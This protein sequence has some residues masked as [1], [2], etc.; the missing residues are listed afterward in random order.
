MPTYTH[1][2]T[3]EAPLDVVWS[4]HDGVDGLLALTPDF[5]HLRVDGMVD[6]AGDPTSGPLE[7]GDRVSLSMKPFGVLPRVSWTSLIVDEVEEDGRAE[8][9]DEMVAGPFDRWVHTHTFEAA[10]GDEATVCRDR[11]EYRPSLWMGDGLGWPAVHLVLALVF[12]YRH[13]ELARR[14]A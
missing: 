1:E 11:V 7:P 3:V 14:L 13:R 2:S 5:L 9:V 10:D 12:R 4:F 6:E 8:F